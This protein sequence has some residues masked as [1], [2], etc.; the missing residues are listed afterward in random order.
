MKAAWRG[1]RMD[2]HNAFGR[3]FEPDAEDDVEALLHGAIDSPAW[4]HIQRFLLSAK[5]LGFDPRDPDIAA[6]AIRAGEA[7]HAA[8]APPRMSVVGPATAHEPV[9]YYM[10]LGDLIKIG[11]TRNI[12][13]RVATLNPEQVLA[14][15]PGDRIQEAE[16]HRQ[17]AAARRHGEWFMRTPDLVRH[18]ADLR[19]RFESESGLTLDAWL[20]RPSPRSKPHTSREST[21]SSSPAGR[22]V[23]SSSPSVANA[24]GDRS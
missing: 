9:V 5:A 19:Q 20:D 10:E 13:G 24:S 14:V 22:E 11:T 4:G 16:R 18:A 23:E 21:Q 2:G 17:F 12:V 7:A 15:E 8:Q 6:R 1:V 3:M